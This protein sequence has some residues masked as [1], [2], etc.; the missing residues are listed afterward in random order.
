M[1]GEAARPIE[2]RMPSRSSARASRSAIA[3][4]SSA[5]VRGNSSASSSPPRRPAVSAARAWR[6]MTEA[7]SRSTRSPCA[8]PWSSL[9]RLK[10][11]MSI[12][13]T[14][15]GVLWRRAARSA[16]AAL[17]WKTEVGE[18]GERVVVGHVADALEQLRLLQRHGRLRRERLAELD[19]V[20][21]PRPRLVDVGDLDDAQRAATGRQRRLQQRVPAEPLHVRDLGRRRVLTVAQRDEAPAAG[22]QQRVELGERPELELEAGNRHAAVLLGLELEDVADDAATAIP[23]GHADLVDARERGTQLARELDEHAARVRALTDR[24]RDP[25]QRREADEALLE[26]GDASLEQV[27]LRLDGWV[28]HVPP[29]LSTHRAG[30]MSGANATYAVIPTPTCSATAATA[31]GVS[32]KTRW[33]TPG[34]V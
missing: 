8:W 24:L 9:S 3:L 29:D 34:S 33:P 7:A 30:M 1:L 12:T 19:L 23:L 17:R 2:T 13:S 4:T 27:D 28:R 25:V 10:S 18:P 6:R 26:L 32:S 11:S 5:L 15:S 22:A 14:P 20:G 31:S 21:I 16:A